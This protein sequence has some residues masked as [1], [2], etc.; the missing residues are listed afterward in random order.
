MKVSILSATDFS[1]NAISRPGISLAGPGDFISLLKPRVMSLVML[2]AVTGFVL[3]PG[4][5]H[6][7][8]GFISLLAIALGAGASGALNMWYD[9]DIDR[10]M[11]RTAKRPV[12]SGRITAEAALAFGL[13]LS[14]FSV[15]LLGLVANWFAAGFLAFTIWFYAVFYTMALKRRTTQN[16][17]IGGAA[18]A[19]PPM[20]GWAVVTGGVSLESFVLF[21]IIFL[22]TPPHFWALALFKMGD[23]GKAG[24]PMLPN[25]AG[26]AATR[27]QIFVYSLILVPVG[28]APYLL[29]FASPVYGVVSA[30][31]GLNFLRHGLA[32]FRMSDQDEEM[33][34]AKK[35]FRF[36]IVYL[37]SLFV[38][39]LIEGVIERFV[40]FGGF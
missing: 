8:L 14:I 33:L 22:W 3:A 34:P 5:V 36:S 18:G 16:I 19:F 35:L 15:L 6:P 26:T 39:L 20:V 31:L 27:L 32:V 21:L 38:L 29:G 25:V 24:V 23:Y 12:P 17:V 9:A 37:F 2:T 11:S 7:V 13:S 30:L 4:S 10:L 1:H 28:V 40:G